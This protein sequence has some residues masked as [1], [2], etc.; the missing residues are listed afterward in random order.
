MDCGNRL[1]MSQQALLGAGMERSDVI[2]CDVFLREHW[3]PPSPG[4]GG[5]DEWGRV[6]RSGS[7]RH[8]DEHAHLPREQQ[9]KTVI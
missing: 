8:Q 2:S 5:S 3:N 1:T 4:W 7:L 6:C 9:E